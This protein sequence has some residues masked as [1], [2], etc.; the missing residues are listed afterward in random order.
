M[1]TEPQN[2]A[3]PLPPL[4]EGYTV[5]LAPGVDMPEYTHT[6]S[7]KKSFLHPSAPPPPPVSS[8]WEASTD[9]KGRTYYLNHETRTSTWAN[10]VEEERLRR[11]RKLEEAGDGEGSIVGYRTAEGEE[12]WVDY[13]TGK[14]T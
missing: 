10:P 12:W 9:A 1:A 7:A 14:L 4:P 8:P 6:A 3:N 13:R 11:E 5:S 2:G